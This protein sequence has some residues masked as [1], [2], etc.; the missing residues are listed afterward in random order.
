[1]ADILQPKV[2]VCVPIYRVASFI[3]RCARSLFE[4]TLKEI[5]YIF[6]DDCS[7]DDSVAILLRV[8]EEYPH[9]KS[10]VRLVR[11]AKNRGSS[12]ART[13]ALE[14]VTGEYVIGCDSDDWVEPFAY[15]AMYDLAKAT[16]SD[17]VISDYYV[18]YARKQLYI[19]QPGE[20]TGTEVT[21]LL[22]SGKLHCAVWNKLVRTSIYRDNDLAP[23]PGV[24]MWEDVILS[25]RNAYFSR[26]VTH[27]PRACMHYNQENVNSYTASACYSDKVIE[28]LRRVVAV[29]EHFFDVHRDGGVY[30]QDLI[31]LKLNVNRAFLLHTRGDKRKKLLKL[32]PEATPYIWGQY[33]VPFYYRLALWLANHQC[34]CGASMVLS[35]VN[36]L[37]RIL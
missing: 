27:L 19:S 13:T 10:Q 1:M 25:I 17:M 6:V 31:W 34:M 24:N 8:L 18:N 14:F 22:L 36:I 26:K 33:T 16:G 29:M 5:E 32:Y 9:R 37:K 28:D 7:P 11:H 35:S 30:E 2:S 23:E 4:Q 15:E 21:R 12:G 3:E 20:G